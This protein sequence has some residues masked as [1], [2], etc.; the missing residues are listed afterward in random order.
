[1]WNILIQSVSTDWL[2]P[3]FFGDVTVNWSRPDVT[4]H[5]FCKCTLTLALWT[6]IIIYYIQET[7]MSQNN[8]KSSSTTRNW[9]KLQY[10]DI[11][12]CC[13][14]SACYV[15]QKIVFLMILHTNFWWFHTWILK[16][17]MIPHTN[18]REWSCKFSISKED[19]INTHDDFQF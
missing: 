5:F 18:Y 15:Y 7:Y 2:V 10:A 11:L 3:K 12:S 4:L 6:L 17:L 9:R 16:C 13:V 19:N 8:F 1:M 14:T